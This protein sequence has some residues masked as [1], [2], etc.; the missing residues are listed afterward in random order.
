MR[1]R[2]IHCST[3][4]S[5]V[6]T[7]YWQY[8]PDSMSK[9]QRCA[10][11]DNWI[12]RVSVMIVGAEK[13]A[14]WHSGVFL[15]VQSPYWCSE[16]CQWLCC[17]LKS[18]GLECLEWCSRVVLHGVIPREATPEQTLGVGNFIGAPVSHDKSQLIF[19]SVLIASAL[20]WFHFSVVSSNFN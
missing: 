10:V 3:L 9:V 8:F 15:A 19:I 18:L 11:C 14:R 13:S 4:H 12:W 2:W 5:K 6:I 1:S 17:T 16:P 7:E 20:S